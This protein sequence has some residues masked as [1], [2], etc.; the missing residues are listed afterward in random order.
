M[1]Q[2]D[3]RFIG[4]KG[5]ILAI[6]IIA[7]GLLAPAYC[8]LPGVTLL[9]QQTPTQ[10]GIITPDT[11]IYH[12]APNSEVAL[13]AIPKPG[14]RFVYWLGDVSEPTTSYTVVHLDEPKIVVAVFEP[15]NNDTLVASENLPSSGGGGYYTGGGLSPSATDFSRP[16]ATIMGGGAGPRLQG[17]VSLSLQANDGMAETPEPAT[18]VLLVLGGMFVFARRRAKKQAQ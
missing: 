10:G 7:G 2:R 4:C 1:K 9:L 13:T 11:G 18:G 8:Q 15:I 16:A 17:P 3:P 12:Y 14:Y 5:I 6:I